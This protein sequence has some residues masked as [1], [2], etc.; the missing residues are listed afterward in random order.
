MIVLAWSLCLYVFGRW[1]FD[2]MQLSARSYDG[3]IVTDWNEHAKPIAERRKKPRSSE[4]TV[5]THNNLWT[6]HYVALV[7][8]VGAVSSSSVNVAAVVLPSSFFTVRVLSLIANSCSD[9]WIR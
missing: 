8:L 3:V 1:T 2:N 4:R 5:P 9:C 6:C 7:V